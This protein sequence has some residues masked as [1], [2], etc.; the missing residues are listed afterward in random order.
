MKKQYIYET[1]VD[2]VECSLSW[3]NHIMEDVW[4]SNCCALVY[5]AIRQKFETPARDV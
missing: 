2:L 1:L 5:V 4:C 3:N